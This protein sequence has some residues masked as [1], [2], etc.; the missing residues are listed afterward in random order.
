[1]EKYVVL[2]S[3][4]LSSAMTLD[5]AINRY[6]IKNVIALFTDT[7]W[8]DEDNYRFMCDIVKR[9]PKLRF[10]FRA[11]GRTPK[12]VFFSTRFLGNSRLGNCSVNLKVKQT[13]KFL[14]EL[15]AD[16]ITPIIL[17]GIGKHE[18]HRAFDLRNKYP[19]YKCLFPMVSEPM[20]NES[21]T[22][23]IEGE[24]DIKVPRMYAL[25]FSHANCGG[26][27][28]RGGHRHWAH[29]YQVWPERYREVE[30]IEEE[31]RAE[32]NPN[33]TIL[34]RTIKGHK[35]PMSLKEFRKEMEWNL[36]QYLEYEEEEEEEEVCAVC[37]F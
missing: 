11:D 37:V 14:E 12:Q 6:G 1:M 34:T 31:F 36:F 3:T 5:K 33:V 7:Q 4:G 22:K 2:F 24:W 16:G 23:V 29:L 25:N 19:N 13:H 28:V 21:M 17:F 35:L 18:E 20:T 9:Y 30:A 27:C 8:E 10:E 26:R 15:K 32:I